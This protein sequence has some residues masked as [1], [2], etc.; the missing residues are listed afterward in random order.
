MQIVDVASFEEWRRAWSPIG[1]FDQRL[2]RLIRDQAA[3][4]LLRRD[5]AR[6]ELLAHLGEVAR[7]LG[8]L[9]PLPFRAVP[10]L[11]GVQVAE[12]SR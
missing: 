1:N 5:A 2:A 9:V 12:S 6:T 4:W 11:E 3:C 10:G 8:V 7:G